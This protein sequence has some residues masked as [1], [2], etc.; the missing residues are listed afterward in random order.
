MKQKS[1]DIHNNSVNMDEKKDKPEA[2]EPEYAYYH[3]KIQFFSSFDEETK[4]K[5]KYWAGLTYIEHLENTVQLIAQI[6][7]DELI[8]IQKM[9]KKIKFVR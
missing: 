8:N 6:Y 5:Y 1:E 4:A 2:G 9:S 3:N 7:K